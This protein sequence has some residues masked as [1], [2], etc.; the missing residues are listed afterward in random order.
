[1]VGVVWFVTYGLLVNVHA[2]EGDLT[3]SSHMHSCTA[4]L[5]SL[6][7]SSYIR[8]GTVGHF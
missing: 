5:S 8:E 1:M 6:D 4:I 7:V 3:F 2:S